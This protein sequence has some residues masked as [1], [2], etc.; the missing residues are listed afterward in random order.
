MAKGVK[1]T[2]GSEWV[3]VTHPDDV[4]GYPI[5]TALYFDDDVGGGERIHSIYVKVAADSWAK[6]FANT[7]KAAWKHVA[8]SIATADAMRYTDAEVR[9]EKMLVL[10]EG[11]KTRPCV[12]G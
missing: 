3:A 12:L 1:P 2:P 6:G 10:S 11:W 7:E 9:R 4:P 5:G 8:S